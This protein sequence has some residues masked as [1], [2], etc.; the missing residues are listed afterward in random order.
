[1]PEINMEFGIKEG[2]NRDRLI[3]VT[4]EPS[5]EQPQQA[6]DELPKLNPD[7]ISR[8][9]R[10]ATPKSSAPSDQLALC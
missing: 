3:M 6:N 8:P 5:P 2:R 10:K 4:L 9:R 7:A 1:L